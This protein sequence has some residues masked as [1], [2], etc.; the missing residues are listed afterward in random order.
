MA[1]ESIAVLFLVTRSNVSQV[2]RCASEANEHTYGA[3][4][5]ILQEFTV[6]QPIHLVDKLQLKMDAIFAGNL[7]TSQ[8]KN[9]AGYQ[10]M[11]PEFISSVKKAPSN[12]RLS[13]DL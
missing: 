4:R 8:T 9:L 7:A 6:E 2:Q 3:L 5:K 10:K 12:T 1:M 13:L 11:F